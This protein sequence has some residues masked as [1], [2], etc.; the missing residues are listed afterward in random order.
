MQ[1]NQRVHC[2]GSDSGGSLALPSWVT[3]ATGV[4]ALLCSPSC[5]RYLLSIYCVPGAVLDSGDPAGEETASCPLG[6]AP[7]LPC[8]VVYGTLTALRQ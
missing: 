6:K 4:Q 7:S 5:H 8:D 1:V 2:G 3:I